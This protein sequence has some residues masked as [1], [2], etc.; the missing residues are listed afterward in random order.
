MLNKSKLILST[1]I[2]LVA[3]SAALARQPRPCS[4]DGVNTN[5]HHKIFHHPD[6]AKAYGFVK[7]PDG[8]WHVEP[9]CHR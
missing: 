5:H 6:V 4:L 3:G 9:N 1:V 8:T 2:I 7:S